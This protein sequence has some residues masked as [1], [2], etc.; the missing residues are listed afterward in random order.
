MWEQ[1][2]R[3]Y[4]YFDFLERGKPARAELQTYLRGR[5][6]TAFDRLGWDRRPGEPVDD[7]LLR[8]RLIRVLGDLGDQDILAEAGRRFEAFVRQPASLRPALRETVLRLVGRHAD[9]ATYDV[10]LSLARGTTN[11]E[12]RSRT[13]SALAGALD[14]G[15]AA[16]TLRIARSDELPPNLAG[17]LIWGVASGGEQPALAWAFVKDNLDALIARHGVAYRDNALAYLLANSSDPAHAAELAAFAPVQQTA[18]GRV[19]AARA[20]DDILTHAD[21]ATRQ[22]PAIEDWI[23]SRPAKP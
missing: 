14:P 15:L 13:Y 9:R 10:L 16:E 4:T 3:T 19:S 18:G 7:G 17:S 11:T 21:I 12:E 22:L 2:I 5:L 1:A 6:R 20:A 8:V 23:R